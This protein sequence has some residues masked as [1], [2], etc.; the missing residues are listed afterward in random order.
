MPNLEERVCESADPENKP[1]HS[2]EYYLNKAIIFGQIAGFGGF[3]AGAHLTST[4]YTSSQEQIASGAAIGQWLSF[5]AVYVPTACYYLRNRFDS[6]GGLAKYLIK[7]GISMVPAGMCYTAM[8]IGGLYGLQKTGLGPKMSA[9]ISYLLATGVFVGVTNGVIKIF[10][11][12]TDK[13]T[14]LSDKGAD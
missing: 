1:E 5:H 13:Q 7:V 9:F 2:D 12:K 3:I 11:I 6:L 4:L 10:G 14:N 8:S